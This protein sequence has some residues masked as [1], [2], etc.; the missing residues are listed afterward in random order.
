LC[1]YDKCALDTDSNPCKYPK[2]KCDNKKTEE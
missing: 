2:D 1:V